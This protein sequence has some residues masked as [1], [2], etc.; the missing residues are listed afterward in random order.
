MTADKMLILNLTIAC[1]WPII[2]QKR[3]MSMKR[4]MLIILAVL[5]AVSLAACANGGEAPWLYPPEPLDPSMQPEPDEISP[6]LPERSFVYE[7]V[8][9]IESI[10]L[11]DHDLGDD[12]G[13]LMKYPLANGHGQ[14]NM[15]TV[16][17]AG[18]LNAEHGYFISCDMDIIKMDYLSWDETSAIDMVAET[19][20]AD[21]TAG[22]FFYAD[23]TLTETPLRTTNDGMAAFLAIG[24][25]SA[26]GTER[27]MVCYFAQNIP[28]TTDVIVLK[29]TL[30]LNFLT[31]SDYAVLTE[32]G[33]HIGVDFVSFADEFLQSL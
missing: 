33:E 19:A 20:N 25:V 11:T 18:R 2:K 15:V 23:S 1:A 29:I 12:D 17:R 26:D 6:E 7:I 4:Q 24:E 21:K 13:P 16:I 3:K 27:Y 8:A 10:S 32:I 22:G 31:D 14:H 28:E 9:D 5:M 30:W